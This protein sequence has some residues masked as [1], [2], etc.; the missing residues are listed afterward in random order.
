[1]HSHTVERGGFV[2]Q[3]ITPGDPKQNNVNNRKSELINM[4]VYCT[5]MCIPSPCPKHLHQITASKYDILLGCS[6][7]A[8]NACVY[9]KYLALISVCITFVY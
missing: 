2:I 3:L 8:E 9:S 5:V 7:R 4:V 6:Q 1:M